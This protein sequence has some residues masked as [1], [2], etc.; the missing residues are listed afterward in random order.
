MLSPDQMDRHRPVHAMAMR[1]AI[2]WRG[3]AQ[4]VSLIPY[5]AL[6][7]SGARSW[8]WLWT[9]LPQPTAHRIA[10]ACRDML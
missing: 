9:T 6:W 1:L 7:A 3:D 5:A 2:A 4:L 8:T 10:K